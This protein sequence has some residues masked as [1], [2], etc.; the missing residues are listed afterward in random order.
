MFKSSMFNT[1]ELV[2]NTL[3]V[4][5]SLNGHVARIDNPNSIKE[6]FCAGGFITDITETRMNRLYKDGFI[7]KD[8]SEEFLKGR[9]R[10]YERVFD[11]TLSLV[12]LST[13]QCNFRCKYCYESF[14]RGAITDECKDAIIRFVKNNISQHNAISVSWFGGEPLLAQ[15]AI[16]EISSSLIQICHNSGKPYSSAIT[17][18]GYLLTPSVL[19]RLRKCRVTSFQVTLD[20]PKEIHD[21]GR[22]LVNGKGTFDVIM[23]NLRSIRDECR[24]STFKIDIRINVTYRLLDYLEEFILFLYHE[25]SC[26]P[27]FSFYFRPV[28]DWGGDRVKEISDNM[29]HSLSSFY[30]IIENSPVALNTDAYI[31]LLNSP[32]CMAAM[33]NHYVIG[34]DATVYKC[35]M[36]FDNP[37]NTIGK[38]LKTGIM[39]INEDLFNRWVMRGFECDECNKCFYS[40]LCSGGTCPAV[41]IA[42]TG[43]KCGYEKNAIGHVLRL[44][45]NDSLNSATC[46]VTRY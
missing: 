31:Q 25:F 33:R 43:E 22:I 29:V 37:L 7:V 21:R 40:P 13:E 35:T 38:L 19:D 36:L 11:S 27:R 6:V 20:G 10:F 18:N 15:D 42:I 5:N 2:D 45:Y 46:K 3:M 23:D 24:S 30:S 1:V 8:T 12:I 14:S 4:Y 34:S 44:I 32:L 28:G 39:E 26:D 9:K 41:G 16:E 17:T